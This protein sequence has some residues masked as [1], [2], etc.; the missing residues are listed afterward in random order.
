MVRGMDHR[1]AWSQLNNSRLQWASPALLL[2]MTIEK[3]EQRAGPARALSL[4][5]A[6]PLWPTCSFGQE[7]KNS[8]QVF[9][10][11]GSPTYSGKKPGP[12]SGWV[13]PSPL[14][15]DFTWNPYLVDKGGV[16]LPKRN[17]DVQRLRLTKWSLWPPNSSQELDHCSWADSLR[18]SSAWS[19]AKSQCILKVS[20][21]CKQGLMLKDGWWGGELVGG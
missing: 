2:W 17:L 15:K 9:L 4:C 11:W 12:G 1:R 3:P 8:P 14:P 6:S 10:S 7:G 21:G 20:M 18:H 19:P 5:D 13:P 16:V